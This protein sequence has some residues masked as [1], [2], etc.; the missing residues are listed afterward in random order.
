[1]TNE[2]RTTDVIYILNKSSLDLQEGGI[3]P[4]NEQQNVNKQN[5]LIKSS[6]AFGLILARNFKSQASKIQ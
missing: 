3:G 1:M 5:K 6:S 4:V 2:S